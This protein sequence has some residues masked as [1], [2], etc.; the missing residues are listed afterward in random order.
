MNRPWIVSVLLLCLLGALWG[1]WPDSQSELRSKANS[2][3]LHESSPAR[4]KSHRSGLSRQR[5]PFDPAKLAQRLEKLHELSIISYL[6]KSELPVIED[7]EARVLISTLNSDEIVQLLKELRSREHE[8]QAFQHLLYRR[9]GTLDPLR[10]R[11]FLLQ[12]PEEKNLPAG[13]PPSRLSHLHSVYKGWSTVNAK[14]AWH[15]WKND[16]A[17]RIPI[18]TGKEATR[19]IFKGF[20]EQLPQQAWKELLTPLDPSQKTL[21]LGSDTVTGQIEG[22]FEGVS[23]GHDWETYAR[24][25]DAHTKTTHPT[26]AHAALAGRWM[27]TDPTAA[28]AWYHGHSRSQSPQ[29]L[30][31]MNVI[32]AL[33]WFEHQPSESTAW[34]REQTSNGELEFARI[35]L[36]QLPSVNTDLGFAATQEILGAASDAES[37][38]QL[39]LH[40]VAPGFS[41]SRLKADKLNFLMEQLK[42]SPE[43]RKEL[44]TKYQEPQSTTHW[45]K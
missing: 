43:L 26:S 10:A 33:N 23:S 35:F 4:S 29:L 24:Q 6:Q 30:A 2:R 16:H 39:L 32:A 14:A 28:L 5:A 37:Q 45:W 34:A 40:V 42:L 25:L 44:T 36:S 41:S 18:L 13:V 9:W 22:F 12:L 38:R 3:E 19:A 31:H 20:A 27:E 21:S 15:Q 8:P 7:Q 17:T 1:T 11:L